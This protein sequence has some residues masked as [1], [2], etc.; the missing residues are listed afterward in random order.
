MKRLLAVLTAGLLIGACGPSPQ[1]D[2][3]YQ[4]LVANPP[5]QVPAELIPRLRSDRPACEVFNQNKLN[6]Y[7]TC[8]WPRGIPKSSA[9]LAY[10]RP[11]PVS[12]PHPSKLISS[13]GRPITEHVPFS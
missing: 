7:M 9:Y 4:A 5:T 3:I 10:Y 11:N 1:N 6:Q 2:P 13:G 8:W 12:P